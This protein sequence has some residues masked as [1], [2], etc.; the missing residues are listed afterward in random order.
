[1]N[2][3]DY[4]QKAVEL[5]D[6]WGF[7]GIWLCY[8]NAGAK[9]HDAEHTMDKSLPDYIKD[10]LAAQLVRQVDALNRVD[11]T[12]HST[13]SDLEKSDGKRWY[14][15]ADSNEDLGR[16]MNT[17]KAIVDGDIF[18]AVHSGLTTDE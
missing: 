4:I 7:D 11:I 14:P 15:L 10:A 1:M 6:G 2:D 8:G 3:Q 5:A 18:T 17:I 9:I 13:F 12:I 16:T